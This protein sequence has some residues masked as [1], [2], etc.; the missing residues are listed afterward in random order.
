MSNVFNEEKQMVF[1]YFNELTVSQKNQIHQMQDV[2]LYWNERINLISRKDIEHLYL[3]HVLHSLSIAK[4][5]RFLPGTEVL[6]VGT[7]G[8]FPG[9]PLAIMFPD[10]IFYLNDSIQ[11]KIK[12]VDE[13]K[14]SLGLQNVVT[15]HDRA[16]KIKQKF[17]FI[18]SRAV[19]NF[20][21]FVQL[22]RGKIKSKHNHPLP[23]GLLYLKGGEMNALQEEM[24]RYY[25][26]A[27][28][29]NITDYFPDIYFETKRVIHYAV[30]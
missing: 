13:I 25:N 22:C 3:H 16:E 30:I 27:L 28:I 4:I 19:T 20:P 29:F 10:T 2:Y 6:D 9:I 12:A 7:G 21:D 18:V 23:N 8:G 26:D 1:Q 15:I 14:K 5:I 11:K 17:D 24:G